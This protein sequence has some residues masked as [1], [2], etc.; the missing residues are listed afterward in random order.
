MSNHFGSLGSSL[1]S[2]FTLPKTVTVFVG[3]NHRPQFGL[4]KPRP[5]VFPT[6]LTKLRT[7]GIN[8]TS[9]VSTS[10]SLPKGT[11]VKVRVNVAL[12]ITAWFNQGA[13]REIVLPS[14]RC[15]EMFRESG[16]WD[17]HSACSTSVTI[18]G[19]GSAGTYFLDRRP[20]RTNRPQT[21]S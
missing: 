3:F 6:V 18:T 11:S 10:V 20:F 2:K 19:T 8:Q 21:I 13:G 14:S 16:C 17:W 9:N 7:C 5:L 15:I 4:S 12:P 1:L